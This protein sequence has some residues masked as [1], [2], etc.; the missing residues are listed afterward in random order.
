MQLLILCGGSGKRLRPFTEDRPKPLLE[1][2]NKP[3]IEYQLDFFKRHGLKDIILCCGYKHELFEE[4]YPNLEFCVE[5]KQLGTAGAIKNAEKLINEDFIVT[6]GDNIFFFNFQ[7][8]Q[9]MFKNVRNPLMTLTKLLSPYGVIDV[10]VDRVIQFREKPVLNLW[11][12]AGITIFTPESLDYFPKEGMIEYDVYPKLAKD[13]KLFAFKMRE[14]AFWL[15]VDTEK[16]LETAKKML[17][18]R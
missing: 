10:E 11:I 1:V 9:T 3:I 16:D 12:N 6:N 17:L 2:L 5:K 4:K 18:K 13:R 7:K 8:M 15:A 14:D